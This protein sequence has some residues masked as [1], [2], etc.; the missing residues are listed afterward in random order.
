MLALYNFIETMF[1]NTPIFLLPLV[2]MNE[3][4]DL[5]DYYKA[6]EKAIIT[7]SFGGK[8]TLTHLTEKELQLR[9]T[10][11]TTLHIAVTPDSTL[12]VTRTF[13]MSDTIQVVARYDRNWQQLSVPIAK[14][15][16]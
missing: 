15:A 10:E 16:D 14:Q 9:T 5:I 3:R 7:N 8:T 1:C 11:S 4:M 12:T 2:G 13:F 6:G